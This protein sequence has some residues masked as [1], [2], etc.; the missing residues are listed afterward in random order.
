[1]K[2][3]VSLEQFFTKK[4]VAK[5]CLTVLN[6]S[7]YDRII[8][9]SAGAGSFSSQIP[10]CEAYDL[11]P[12]GDKI[13]KQD[14][15]KFKT[16]KGNILVIGNPPFGRQSSL[17]I[18]FINN[19]AQFARTIAFILPNSFKK[20]SML[21]KIDKHFYLKEVI[22]LEKNSFFFEEKDYDI[23]CSF[24]VYEYSEKEREAPKKYT[25]EDFEFCKK[26]EADY[27]IRRVGFYAGKIE[28]LNVSEASHY[29]IKDKSNAL[30]VL[31]KIKYLD[32]LNTVGAKSISKNEI[33][34][35]YICQKGKSTDSISKSNS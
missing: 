12:K 24:F 26:E 30:S 28:G 15:L 17:A 25:T 6:L 9:P 31:K 34:K 1:M 13:I 14:F 33:I 2:R 20:E 7:S 8:E 21:S 22:P 18:K 10:N 3:E 4:E 29:F 16:E 5:K 35:E 11:E 27:S 32:A 19:A 23:P